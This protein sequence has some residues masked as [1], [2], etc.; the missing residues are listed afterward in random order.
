LSLDDCDLQI[1]KM[2]RGDS[3]T[4]LTNVSRKVGVS[5][6]GVR[7][8]VQRMFHEGIILGSTV[9]VDPI[10]VGFKRTLFCEFKTNPH[11]PWLATLL[12]NTN[13]CDLL[14]GITGEF[15]LF[16]RLR[17]RDD[18]HFAR[19]LKRIDA[20]V[21]KGYF[22]KYRVV[23]A[24]RIFKES[25]VPFKTKGTSFEMD[26]VDLELLDIL[27][28]QTEYVK[29]PLPISTVKLSSLLKGFGIRISQ[30]AVFQRLTGL[31]KHE[32]IIKNA[33]R[34]NWAMLGLN[35]KVIVRVKANPSA[36]NVVAKDFLAPM[37]EITDLYRTGEEYGLLAVVRVRN[38]SEYNSFLL[39]LYDD[40]D[41]IDTYTTLVLEERKHAPT[42]L[43]EE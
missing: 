18:E 5:R 9:V 7:N 35:T 12:E 19:L 11:E 14:D 21:T 17:M 23:N 2:L 39:R 28:N 8:R 16:A 27:L 30:P 32:I 40:R 38:T 36:Y 3:R 29:A 4:S 13:A 15:S 43:R 20:A 37:D 26:E 10:A 1:M 33:I 42:F 25:E 31:E 22:K 24:I 34:V 6:F 41:V